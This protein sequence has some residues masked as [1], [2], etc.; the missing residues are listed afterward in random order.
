MD[1]VANGYQLTRPADCPED[2]YAAVMR[3][4]LAFDS[5]ERISFARVVDVLAQMKV[6]TI[7]EPKQPRPQ[8][9]T[10]ESPSRVAGY[11]LH[12][13][14]SDRGVRLE[15]AATLHDAHNPRHCT[16]STILQIR[17]HQK[18]GCV[19]R[20]ALRVSLHT[21]CLQCVGVAV[22]AVSCAC[23]ATRCFSHACV[24]LLYY[25]MLS[26]P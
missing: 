23:D 22:G 6:G 13:S 10:A 18:P 24:T 14:R 4:C 16:T 3:P 19:T 21:T 26:A 8:R 1:R 12:V 25:S 17:T 15:T 5:K 9:E 20:F 7:D 11:V 2:F